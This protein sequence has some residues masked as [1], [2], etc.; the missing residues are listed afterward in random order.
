MDQHR[1]PI[2]GAVVHLYEGSILGGALWQ[3]DSA[4]T[5][6]A[7]EATIARRRT[8]HLFVLLVP[9]AEAPSVFG[10]CVDAPGFAALGRVMEDLAT[11]SIDAPL[12]PTSLPAR[13]PARLDLGA[14]EQD[15][16]RFRLNNDR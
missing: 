7:G 9:D 3:R 1:R 15:G 5:S 10:W 4:T 2:A 16:P 8:W 11:Q 6:A 14:I 13:C 12:P